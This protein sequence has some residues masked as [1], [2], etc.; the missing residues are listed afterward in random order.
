MAE[1]EFK[2]YNYKQIKHSLIKS[3]QLP[4]E[5]EDNIK[6]D[7][8][9]L[10]E[11]YNRVV[12]KEHGKHWFADEEKAGVVNEEYLVKDDEGH[13]KTVRTSSKYDYKLAMRQ[14]GL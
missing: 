14:L 13:I 11:D 10:N 5:N 6:E 4:R 2:D 9:E 3:G 8:D 12:F 1:I 7:I